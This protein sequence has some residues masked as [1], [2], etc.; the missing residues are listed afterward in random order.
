MRDRKKENKGRWTHWLLVV[1]LELVVLLAVIAKVWSRFLGIQLVLAIFS[2]RF[3]AV[4]RSQSL[5]E[6]WCF[7]L[8]HRNKEQKAQPEDTT[9]L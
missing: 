5:Q 2:R 4:L 7:R 3:H 6:G 1:I 8:L 9:T